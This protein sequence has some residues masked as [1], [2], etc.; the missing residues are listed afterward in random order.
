[1]R[2]L[3]RLIRTEAFAAPAPIRRE[4][5]SQASHR[6]WY[7]DIPVEHGAE[8]ETSSAP[9]FFPQART[10]HERLQAASLHRRTSSGPPPRPG[11]SFFRRVKRLA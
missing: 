5:G 10:M 4:N 1:L 8:D 6:I 2:L 9:L 7:L 11:F 3:F